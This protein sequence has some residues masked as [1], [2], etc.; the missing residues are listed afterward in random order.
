MLDGHDSY[1]S[2]RQFA[3]AFEAVSYT[4]LSKHQTT[5]DASGDIIAGSTWVCG[6]AEMTA[7]GVF[8]AEKLHFRREYAQ[9]DHDLRII[10]AGDV[11]IGE[12]IVDY[13]DF[14]LGSTGGNIDVDAYSCLL[15]TSRCV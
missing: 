4:H 11:S 7:Q 2:D 8:T 13:G 9:V 5:I 1:F 14:Y 15:Y 12:L 3:S 6:A 10:V